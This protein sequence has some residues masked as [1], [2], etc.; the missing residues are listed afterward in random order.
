MSTLIACFQASPRLYEQ[1]VSMIIKYYPSAGLNIDCGAHIGEHT[2]TMLARDEVSKVYAFEAIPQLCDH[3]SSLFESDPKFKL[4]R[5]ALGRGDG[6]VTFNIAE[7]AKGYSG[8]R[9]R[10]LAAVTGWREI[11]VRMTSI[12]HVVCGAEI[13]TVSLVKL[14]LEGGEFDALQGATALLE[15]SSPLV[16]FENA[17]RE[18]ATE[19][20]Y[21]W[22]EFNSFFKSRGYRVYDFF[23]DEVDNVYWSSVLQT[24]MFIAVR[25]GSIADT[26]RTTVL[27][28]LVDEC[29]ASQS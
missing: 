11:E 22:E 6:V 24:Y 27:P 3:L 28:S 5:G 21:G 2:A 15:K 7:N 9:Q 19:Y 8:L 16:V 14:D 12:D 17:L 1:L 10:D 4:V 18:S 20:G 13:S 29:V 26:W 25:D 23:G